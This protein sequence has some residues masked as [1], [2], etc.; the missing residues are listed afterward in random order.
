MAAQWRREWWGLFAGIL[1]SF[2][3]HARRRGGYF[4]ALT[5]VFL[6]AARRKN[7]DKTTRQR[8]ATTLQYGSAL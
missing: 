2:Y 5:M 1:P 6:Q 8:A 7:P 4:A 3:R